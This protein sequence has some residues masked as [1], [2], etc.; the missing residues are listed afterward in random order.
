MLLPSYMMVS[1]MI[2]KINISTNPAFFLQ[3]KPLYSAKFFIPLNCL[4]HRNFVYCA[5]IKT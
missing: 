4:Q 3:F 1:G 2:I 5:L